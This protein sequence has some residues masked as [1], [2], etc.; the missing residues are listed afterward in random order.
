VAFAAMESLIR[1]MEKQLSAFDRNRDHRAAFLR[2][3][4]RMSRRVLK[5]MNA[6]GFF[7]DPAWIERVALR[8]ADMY[9]DALDAFDAGRRAPPAWQLAFENALNRR[10][11][12]LQ[13]IVLGVNAHIN[14]DLPQVLA[15]ILRDEGDWPHR[16]RL[17]HRRFD[18]DQ[19]N[20]ILHEIIPA[21]EGEVAGHYGRLVRT[22]G[23]AKGRLDEDLAAL[24]L[25]QFRDNTWRCGLFLLAATGEADASTVRDWIEHDALLVGQLAVRYGAPGWARPLAGMTRRLRL[26]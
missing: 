12:L 21:V 18:H 9:F 24:G 5:R 14:N 22:L 25:K 16:D 2:V 3:Y 19:I 15:G 1:R 13:D 10:T 4:A 7:L 6:G 8:F 23:W 26:M 11:F 17:E 20:R